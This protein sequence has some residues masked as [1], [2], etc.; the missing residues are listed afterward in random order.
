MQRVWRFLNSPAAVYALHVTSVYFVISV[1]WIGL[2]DRLLLALIKDPEALTSAQSWK[3]W[4]FVLATTVWLFWSLWL[5]RLRLEQLFDTLRVSEQRF[6][7]LFERM[8][9]IAVQG[10]ST[11]RRVLFWN[12]AS[13]RLYG[14]S[15]DEATS[16]LIEE[17]IIPPEMREDVKAAIAA[18]VERGVTIPPRELFLMRK[19]G[20]RVPVYSSCA[21]LRNS[22]GENEMY[23]VDVDL[24]ALKQAEAKVRLSEAVF[25][26]SAEGI[27]VT[28]ADNRIVSV[29]DAF[30]RITGY[31]PA[32]VMGK[33]PDM[34]SSGRHNYAFYAGMWR[35]LLEYGRWHGDILNRK[36]NGEIYPAW[37]AINAVEDEAG[38]ISHFV[39]ILS[40]N[41]EKRAF[42]EQLEFVANHDALT[43]LPNRVLLRDRTE[44][45]LAQAAREHGSVALAVLDL[46]HFKVIND[47]LGHATGDMLLLAVVARLK[48]CLRETDTFCRQGGDEFVVLMPEDC[49]SEQVASRLQAMLDCLA[50]P[51]DLGGRSLIITA[52]IGVAQ[53]PYDATTVDDLLVKSETAMYHAKDSGRNVFRFFAGQM[54]VNVNERFALQTRL[55]QAIERNEL[56]L[57]FQPQV[58]LRTKRITGAEAL[59]RW[60]DGE[61]AVV[62][63]GKFIPVAEQ[64]GLII[65]IGEWVLH[66]ACRQAQAWRQ[67]GLPDMLMAVNMSALQFKR[68]DPVLTVRKVLEQTGLPPWCLELE[69]TESILVDD[70]DAILETLCRFKNL[71]IQLA[72]DD[73]GTG[74]SSLAYLK[75]FPIDKLKIDQSFVRDVVADADEAAIVHTIIQL[76]KSLKMSTLAEGVETEAQLAFL[77]VEGCREGQGFLFSRPLEADDFYRLVK[78]TGAMA[79]ERHPPIPVAAPER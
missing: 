24:S 54:N 5:G 42:E 28:D 53:Y 37:L 58:D 36:K 38:N 35:G 41:S 77:R 2:S 50:R 66:E 67:E 51:F 29:N 39:A 16:R 55:A 13:E 56:I 12:A 72:I 27:M 32:E 22:Q 8:P 70:A 74:Y 11:E 21:L 10:Y 62:P 52:S 18:W 17:L 15:A 48:S 68:T 47:S 46:D 7:T 76:G 14:Y 73:F 59:V 78:Q 19:D 79:E 1:L 45:A 57:H 64:S 49:A 25:N 6:R 31:Q 44:Q 61:T 63:P 23:C 75:R 33:T 30:C 65:P 71:G 26:D 43:G 20:S 9:A 69:L 34:F 4:F 3:G 40:D 60:R